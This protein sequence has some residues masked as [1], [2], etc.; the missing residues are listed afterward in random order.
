MYFA[1]RSTLK[2]KGLRCK[3]PGLNKKL[4][5]EGSLTGREGNNLQ[6]SG[7]EEMLVHF[8]TFHLEPTQACEVES[9]KL[10]FPPPTLKVLYEF[11]VLILKNGTSFAQLCRIS[12]TWHSLARKSA[13]QLLCEETVA[14]SSSG[15]SCLNHPIMIGRISKTVRQNGCHFWNRRSRY[16]QV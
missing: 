11:G 2:N 16:T 5:D 4:A 1:P 12:E 14:Q 6:Y 3:R 7:L 8:N 9:D 13:K 10:D 15:G